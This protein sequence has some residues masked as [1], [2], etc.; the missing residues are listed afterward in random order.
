MTT[1]EGLRKLVN[2]VC[3]P[4]FR[5]HGFRL[6]KFTEDR[7]LPVANCVI[8]SDS[9]EIY[10]GREPGGTGVASEIFMI[11]SNGGLIWNMHGVW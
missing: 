1:G 3:E 2:K 9:I 10:F 11:P 7:A 4:L 5:A 6:V 8:A